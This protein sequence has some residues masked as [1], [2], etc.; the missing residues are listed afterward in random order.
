MNRAPLEPPVVA[1]SS[2][3][4]LLRG[5][6]ERDVDM[7]RDLATDPYL[8]KIGTLP[9]HA[10]RDQA[11]AYIH[12]Q[13]D[14][15]AT[16]QGYSFCIAGAE[17][18]AALGGVGLWL[19]SI[20]AGRATAGYVVAPLHRGHGFARDALTAL[21]LFAWSIED[22]HRVELYIEP[23]NSASMRTAQAA[24]FNPEGLLRSHREIGGRRVDMTIH[25]ITR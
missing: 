24:G 13:R 11:L 19:E 4:V 16:G 22:L 1:P 15:L 12:R 8:P 5:Y 6:E 3:R 10:D 21:T 20:S 14:R 25:A 17:T 9:G 23:W 7:V 18:D 2:G